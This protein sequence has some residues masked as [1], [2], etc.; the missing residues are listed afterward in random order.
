M[1]ILFVRSKESQSDLLLNELRIYPKHSI[2]AKE[3]FISS[4]IVCQIVRE[5]KNKQRE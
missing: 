2:G 4:K 5:I 1:A 3:K